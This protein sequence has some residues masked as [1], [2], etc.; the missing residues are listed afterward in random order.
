[1]A[2]IGFRLQKLVSG[3][4]YTDLIKA[5][6]FSS[7]IASG[8]M[9]IV[10]FSLSVVH[11]MG[12]AW[13]GPDEAQYFIGIAVYCF[14]AAMLGLGGPLNIVTRYLAD[15][16]FHQ[17]F[18]VFTPT[19]LS[20]FEFVIVLQSIPA[21][22]F[23]YHAPI[24]F[25]EKWLILI[26]FLLI[27]GI[28]LAMAFLSAA[29]SFMA[30]VFAYVLGGVASIL[31]GMVLGP[32][33]GFTGVLAAFT[34]GQAVTFFYLLYRLF[35]EFGYTTSHNFDFMAYFLQHPYLFAIGT[36]LNL[37]VWMDKFIMWSSPLS[38]RLGPYLYAAPDYDTPIFLAFVCVVPSMAFFLIQMETSF[39]RAYTTYF[40]SISNRQDWETILHNK[41]DMLHVITQ[42]FQKFIIFQGLISGCAILL[43]FDIAEIL[44][45]NTYQLG[46]F[47][48]GLLAT[49]LQMGFSMFLNIYFYFDFQREAFWVT[50]AFCASNAV[51]TVLS[52][53]G[54]HTMYG[55]GFA[56]A[57]CVG[58]LLSFIVLDRK[59]IR[60]DYWTFMGQPIMIP[61]FEVN[62]ATND[63]EDDAA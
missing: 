5:Y 7:I 32:L 46:I 1:M 31:S 23:L 9:L 20:A 10:I 49:F 30:I 16:Y 59:L 52:L 57:C 28:W 58:L 24:L 37:G 54:G 56:G 13:M 22:A 34:L 14:A 60:L 15:H 3:E 45:L 44:A 19:F 36:L 21:C 39:A 25:H 27:N 53:Q 50:L 33:G 38:E 11:G 12:K 63:E 61:K 42:N 29:K 26:C 55:F 48:I 62:T 41:E 2:G 8:P 17:N 40:R 51:F 6:A 18:E 4:S 47:R 35:R 43:V